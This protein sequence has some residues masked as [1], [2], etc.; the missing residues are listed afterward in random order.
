MYTCSMLL[1]ANKKVLMILTILISK[2]K[3]SAT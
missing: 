2:S 3:K 1:L